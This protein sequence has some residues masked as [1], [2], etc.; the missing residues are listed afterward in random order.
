[1]TS[2]S[3]EI[4][5]PDSAVRPQAGSLDSLR[6]RLDAFLSADR[7]RVYP[8]M[9]SVG[10][11][12]AWLGTVVLGSG[13]L[14]VMGRPWGPDFV[15][16]YTAADVVAL[17]PAADAY[18]G[19]LFDDRQDA[20]FPDRAGGYTY[21]LNPPNAL[22]LY[23][24][25][26]AFDYRVAI[27]LWWALNVA[28]WTGAHGL[29]HRE[30]PDWPLRRKLAMSV[31][32]TPTLLWFSYG[33]ATGLAFFVLVGAWTLLR[34]GAEARAGAVLALLAFK[35][36]LALGLAL[37]LFFRMRWRALA[38]GALVTG[39]QLALAYALWPAQFA[40]FAAALPEITRLLHLPG[41]ITWG[42]HTISA[43]WQLLLGGLAPTL[44]TVAT[45]CTTLLTLGALAWGWRHVPWEPTDARWQ[46]AMAA[47]V[48]AGL[49]LGPHLWAYDLA[50]LLLPFWVVVGARG[51]RPDTRLGGG[52]FLQLTALVWVLSFLWLYVTNAMEHLSF[53]A[54]G[55]PVALQLLVPVLLFA[56]WS[57]WPHAR[58]STT[59]PRPTTG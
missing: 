15:A 52:S 42:I 12:L 38:A 13:G 45:A 6:H 41:G 39:L 8:V 3:R 46:Q 9:A 58:A 53:Q 51:I 54:L 40:Y 10:L 43:F 59:D 56:A 47:T 1:M 36:Q 33:Q 34:R 18:L 25:F 57:L 48:V 28:A 24:P 7:L 4:E 32:F 30:A 16:L 20:L 11:F 44:A 14:D 19:P 2:A 49:L 29:L 23:R 50:L 26:A 22:L 17:D 27:L 5:P 55:V 35:P 31:L 37:P 21:W